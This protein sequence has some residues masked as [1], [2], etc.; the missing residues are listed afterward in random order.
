MLRLIFFDSCNLII[1]TY[2]T[3][4]FSQLI[5][6]TYWT[7]FDTTKRNDENM[8]QQHN[9]LG[10]FQNEVAGLLVSII[11]NVEMAEISCT[12][13]VETKGMNAKTNKDNNIAKR[14]RTTILWICGL[15]EDTSPQTK[16]DEMTQETVSCSSVRI[17]KYFCLDSS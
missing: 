12:D 2:F 3:H 14:V 5:R 13:G 4:Y 9:A 10:E 15:D 16:L 7:R 17:N 6:T 8:I 1:S 11:I